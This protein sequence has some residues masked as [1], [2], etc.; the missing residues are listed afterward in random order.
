MD[1]NNKKLKPGWSKGPFLSIKYNEPK[2]INCQID[3]SK[4]I[5]SSEPKP[6]KNNK[7]IPWIVSGTKSGKML[8]LLDS[9]KMF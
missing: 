5:N 8:N 3:N 4:T 6:I 9:F 7:P 2:P 1:T